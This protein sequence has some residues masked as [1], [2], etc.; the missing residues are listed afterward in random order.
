MNLEN[1]NRVYFIG[2]GGIGM[3]ALARY[4]N[5]KGTEVF[6]YDK[7]ATTLTKKLEGEGMKIHYEED[8]ESIPDHVDLVV[9]TPAIPDAHC[10]LEYF[11]SEGYPVKKRAEVLGIISRNLKT[12]AVA[13]T[14]GKTTTSSI[15]AHVLKTGGID[16]TAFLG[17]IAQNFKSNFVWGKD[18]WTVIEADEYDR[19]FLHLTPDIAIVLS[20][21]PDHLD[22]Y[23]EHETLKATFAQFVSQTK[24]GGKVL[25]KSGL[26]LQAASKELITFGIDFGDYSATNWAVKKGL[27]TFDVKSPKV[28][29]SGVQFTMAGK[30]NSEN[31]MAAIAVAQLLGIKEKDIIKALAS[32]K[33]IKRRFERIYENEKVVYIDDYAHHPTELK[34]AIDAARQLFPDRKI[35]G[36]FQPH[37]YSRTQDF[38]DGFAKS[39]D[40]LDEVLLMAIYPA[41]ELPIEGVSSAIILDKMQ[42]PNCELVTKETVMT[43]LQNRDLD[44]LL[45]LGAGDIDTFVEPIKSMLINE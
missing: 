22:I 9:Y 26:P 35:T 34:A 17:G 23:G 13:G 41:R 8:L 27:S 30:H 16:C 38:A 1:L 32:F 21:D 31:A 3:S 12:I 40:E 10:E 39:L 4:F 28:N 33:G 37:L 19:S 43:V 29:I 20:M 44:V 42:N 36:V 5:R 2:I 25:V 18:D 45:T 14:H 24:T 15:V 7:T 6:G 11:K